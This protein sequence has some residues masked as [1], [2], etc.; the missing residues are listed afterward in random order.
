[1]LSD[2]QLTWMRTSAWLTSH[3]VFQNRDHPGRR[4]KRL[5]L[6]QLTLGKLSVPARLI[7]PLLNLVIENLVAANPARTGLKELAEQVSNLQI[8][9]SSSFDIQWQPN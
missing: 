1:M 3:P 8:T 9:G 4:A 2:E 7:D 6:Q 5:K